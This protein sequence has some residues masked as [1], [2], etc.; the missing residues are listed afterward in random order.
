MWIYNSYPTG[1][2]YEIHKKTKPSLIR[3]FLLKKTH[4]VWQ[5]FQI[6]SRGCGEARLRKAGQETCHCTGSERD[7]FFLALNLTSASVFLP[8]LILWGEVIN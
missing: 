1:E 2:R 3:P 4:P 8:E 6:V 7:D 5:G